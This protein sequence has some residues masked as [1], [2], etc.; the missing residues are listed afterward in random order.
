MHI[1]NKENCTGCGA[2]YN[3]C[4]QNAITMEYNEYGFYSPKIDK[5]KCINCGLCEKVCPLDNYK[6]NNFENPRVYA[7]QNKDEE[8]LYKCAS[9]GAFAK[10]ANNIIEQNG[11]VYGVVYDENMT[12]CHTRCDN[13]ED[14]EK[15]YSSKYVQS[16]TGETFE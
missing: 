15:M 11:I 9:G 3:I 7:F 4:P 10:L 5:E 14:L 8:I 2:C 16:D 13:I 1:E 12:V 6:S